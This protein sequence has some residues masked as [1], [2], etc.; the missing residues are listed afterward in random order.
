MSIGHIVY[1]E[2]HFEAQIARAAAK[3]ATPPLPLWI[4]NGEI[5]RGMDNL[6]AK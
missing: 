5:G 6:H 2:E 3:T 1:C 4:I